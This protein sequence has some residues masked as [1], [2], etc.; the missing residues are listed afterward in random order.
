MT[1][2]FDSVF[3]LGDKFLLEISAVQLLFADGRSELFF[4]TLLNSEKILVI[5][6]A[7]RHH[8]EI[9][10]KQAEAQ[11][12]SQAEAITLMLEQ[13]NNK[14]RLIESLNLSWESFIREYSEDRYACLVVLEHS[15][16]VERIR[17]MCA[18]AAFSVCVVTPGEIRPYSHLGA[19]LSTELSYS[20]HPVSKTTD[21]LDAKLHCN[22]G[23]KVYDDEGQPILLTEKISTGAEG[24]VFRTDDPKCVAKIYHTG[25]ITPLRWR[26]LIHMTKK[27]INAI[28][29]CWPSKLLYTYNK[30]PV[31]FLMQVG[32][33]HTL[34]SVFDG[35]DA[36]LAEYPEW[37]R[38]D[39][40]RVA[41]RVL[42][43]IMYLHIHGVIIGD[44]QM[45]NMMMKD[46]EHIYLIDMDSV[47]IEDMPCPVGTEEYTSP[48]LWDYSFSDVLRRPVHEDFSC[49]ILVFSILFCGQHPY[50]QR[51]GKETLREEIME[52]SFPYTHGSSE[53]S[54]VPIGGYDKI[55]DALTPKLRDL[56][57]DAFCKG[58]RYEPVE[59]YVAVLEYKKELTEK[60]YADDE[61]YRLFPHTDH[62]RV[63]TLS[64][65]PKMY[66]KTLREAMIDASTGGAYPNTRTNVSSSEN[67]M[68]NSQGKPVEPQ[69]AANR[70]FSNHAQADG[71]SSATHSEKEPFKSSDAS[72]PATG[73]TAKSNASRGKPQSNSFFMSIKD[74]VN[75]NKLLLL[76]S[77]LLALVFTLLMILIGM[78]YD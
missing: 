45:K 9:I 38:L 24:I 63:G 65:K 6:K 15:F 4:G 17:D 30:L 27:G 40:V 7:F 32:A 29:I 41:L 23:D 76:L 18:P 44:I 50:A 13:F 25:V 77:I 58:T 56:F 36:M 21:Y 59:W 53:E 75:Q 14:G 61:A 46:T 39:V 52:K 64:D 3:S 2:S 57:A 72:K 33:G 12:K 66:K 49:A 16:A 47:Q 1:E 22:V 51:F 74:F 78:V 43:K 67:L 54:L 73:Q 8:I 42:E 19:F 71:G 34:G 11:E 37:G 20:V 28:G 60:I 31:G 48:E 26:K 10:S 70:S 55:W 68:Y 5:N 69:T 62:S 35:P